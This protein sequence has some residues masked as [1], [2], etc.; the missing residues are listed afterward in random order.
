MALPCLVA[1]LALG[2]P[3]VAGGKGKGDGGHGKRPAGASKKKSGDESAKG[4]S[5][6]PNV[7]AKPAKSKPAAGK[8]RGASTKDDVK[9]PGHGNRDA[10]PRARASATSISSQQDGGAKKSGSVG[11]SDKS[12]GDA[13]RSRDSSSAGAAGAAGAEPKGGGKDRR[14]RKPSG[15]KGSSRQAQAPRTPP[16][17]APTATVPR[18]GAAPGRPPGGAFAGA[19][20]IDLA[21]GAPV[22]DSAA[23]SRQASGERLRVAPAS[24]PVVRTIRR[25]V[26]VIPP[27]IWLLV[28][29]LAAMTLLLAAGSWLLAHRGRRLERQREALLEDVG[30][31]QRALLPAAPEQIAGVATSVAYRPASGPDAGGVFYDVF[32]LDDDRL[33]LLIG[34][35]SIRGRSALGLTALVRHTVRA[36]LEAGVQ[37][38]TA[39]QLGARVLVHQLGGEQASVTT[40]V[41][42]REHGIL[43]YA[44]AGHPPPVVLGTAAFEPITACASPPI[45][46]PEPTGLRQTTVSLPPGSVVCFYTDGVVRTPVGA[47]PFGYRRLWLALGELGVHGD[48][49]SLLERIGAKADATRD[50]MAACLL[51]VAHH[52]PAAAS[53]G[54]VRRVEELEVFRG[55]LDTDRPVEF[56]AACGVPSDRVDAL[57]KELRAVGARLGGAVLRV[58]VGS[59]PPRAEL[60]LNRVEL[61][62]AFAPVAQRA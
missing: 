53:G 45:G 7:S 44:A 27:V 11:V 12:A 35:L 41:Y 56:L 46:A 47:Q 38:R 31:L 51:R 16:A 49:R 58:M 5:G 37:P 15:G 1:V 22:P 23:P 13:R 54:G 57:V 36:Y 24:S 26:E 39:L 10:R 30:L 32:A 34:E 25:V 42:D 59:G 14:G 52:V 60:A 55:D 8:R 43:T 48:A 3:A 29:V 33:G 4:K 61:L 2:V 28:A 18:L 19:A 62:P 6:D 9:S 21:P 40:A 17:S 50:D 20:P